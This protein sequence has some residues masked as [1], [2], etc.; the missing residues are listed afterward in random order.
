[1]GHQR[2]PAM[3]GP[4]GPAMSGRQDATGIGPRNPAPSGLREPLLRLDIS[5][6][7]KNFALEI[8]LQVEEEI[9]VLF[10]PSGAG[11]TSTLRAVAGLLTPDSG[12]ILYDGQVFF[13][14]HRAGS[15]VD[16]P[17]RR[18]G[19]GYLFQEYALFP[20]LDAVGNVAYGLGRGA[21]ARQTA[22]GLLE[23]M[24][25]QHLADRYPAEMSGG[26]QQRVALAR[27]VARRPRILLLDE[28]FSA[29]DMTLRERLRR[30]IRALQ[31]ELHLV[32]LCVTHNLE[33]AVALGDRLAVIQDGE[34]KQ[35]G[36]VEDVFNRPSSLQAAEAVGVR[37][38]FRA[39][40]T[41]AGADHVRLDWDGLALMAPA[42]P[43]APGTLVPVYVRPEDIKILY[44][45]RPLGPSLA[46][47]QMDALVQTVSV[48]GG[49]R[50]LRLSLSN[51]HEV[52]VR[53]PA[54]VYEEL[55]L[56]PGLRVQLSFR[57]EGILVLHEPG[58]T[59]A[60]E[61]RVPAAG[62]ATG[63]RAPA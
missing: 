38:L 21:E 3:S 30:D 51:G 31:Q 55:D 48:N 26:Q 53:G 61:E 10:G 27:A 9:L 44:P 23:R 17:P 18:R 13:R 39:R 7:L 6:K 34:V 47:N 19:I 54:Y 20:H 37:N 14:R 33:D 57:E 63:G 8:R 15:A 59:E 32:V 11:K 58:E 56:K 45:D 62:R 52:E 28:P 22:L 5:K 46:V 49:V 1:V 60:A 50:T 36:L 16:L 35:V 4:R 12:E 25:L 42:Q 41:S 40:V 43:A 29:L 24:R 2:D